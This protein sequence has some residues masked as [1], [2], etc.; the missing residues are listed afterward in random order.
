MKLKIFGAN[1]RDQS[2][3]PLRQNLMK[4]EQYFSRLQLRELRAQFAN[5]PKVDIDGP[6]FKSMKAYLKGLPESIRAQ[7]AAN[8]IQWLSILARYP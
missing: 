3:G 6:V 4:K 8:N 5:V 2:K 1:L 7:L